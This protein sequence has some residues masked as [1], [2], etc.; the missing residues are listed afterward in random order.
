MELGNP[1]RVWPVTGLRFLFVPG[2]NHRTNS[3]AANLGVPGPQLQPTPSLPAAWASLEECLNQVIG[4][5]WEMALC[6]FWIHNSRKCIKESYLSILLQSSRLFHQR[7]S[8][9]AWLVTHKHRTQLRT[10][11]QIPPLDPD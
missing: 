10:Y 8:C 1:V 2:M 6:N 4:T 5:Q 9:Q 11:P 3:V 7:F